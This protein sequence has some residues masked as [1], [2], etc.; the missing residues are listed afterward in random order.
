MQ[1]KRKAFVKT[2]GVNELGYADF[3]MKISNFKIARLKFLELQDF[4]FDS[5]Y[6]KNFRSWKFYRKY[7]WKEKK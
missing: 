3:P 6:G 2:F 5:R 7:Q 1:E 4:D